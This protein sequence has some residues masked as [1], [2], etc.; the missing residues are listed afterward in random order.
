MIAVLMALEMS[1]ASAS[2]KRP[3]GW[4]TKVCGLFP[5]A[6]SSS[7]ASFPRAARSVTCWR[8]CA[9]VALGPSVE[10]R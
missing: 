6:T 1:R 3:I 7:A 10:T 2:L 9:S 8:I 5:I 4:R